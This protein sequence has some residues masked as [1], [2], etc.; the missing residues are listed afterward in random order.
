MSSFND[1]EENDEDKDEDEFTKWEAKVRRFCCK[2]ENKS[3]IIN[4]NI[5]FSYLAK[6]SILT[7]YQLLS[8]NYY[9]ICI[10]YWCF[11]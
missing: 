9:H 2:I 4:L 7:F 6:E 1:D 8:F 5:L 10:C 3:K 11:V